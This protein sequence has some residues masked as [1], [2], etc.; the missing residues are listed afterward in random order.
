MKFGKK[1]VPLCPITD[2]SLQF[3]VYGLQMITF[4]G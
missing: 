2:G 4:I 3:T 1:D